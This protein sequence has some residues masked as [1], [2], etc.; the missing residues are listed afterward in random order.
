MK[1]LARHLVWWP[2]MDKDVEDVVK[3]CDDCQQNRATP[4]PG[5]LHPWQWPTR[6]W[7]RLHIDFAGPTEGKMLLIIVDSHSKWI[8]AFAMENATSAATLRYLRQVFAQFGIPETVVS[9]NGTQF[10]SDEFKEFCRLNGIRHVQ[11]APYHPSSN[12]LAERAVQVVKQ[13]IRKQS[14]GTLNDRISRM[15]FQYRITPHSTTGV[16]PSELLFGRRLRS[17]LDL[18]KPSMEERVVSKQ[19]KQKELHDRHSR[20]YNFTVGER[21]YV[22]NNR[23]GQKWLSG[24][25]IAKTGPVSFK[26]ELQ[27]G[28]VIRCHQ[29]QIRLRYTEDSES[30]LLNEDDVNIFPR[31]QEPQVSK[32]EVLTDTTTGRHYP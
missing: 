31:A 18:L 10:V 26:V 23:K 1:A 8:E 16:S 3:H 21:V 2:K 14:S 19:Q 28:K 15:L 6:P 25:V 32:D 7:T 27:D 4:P 20:A 30:P 24:L 11:T 17:R 29:D 12:G 9:D 13:G 5:P 22:K